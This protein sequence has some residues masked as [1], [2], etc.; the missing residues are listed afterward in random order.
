MTNALWVD[1]NVVHIINNNLPFLNV[2]TTATNAG[3]TTTVYIKPS[4]QRFCLNS[5]S[6]CPQCYRNSI[7]NAYIRRALTHCSSWNNTH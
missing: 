3:F 2:L 4:N 6:E 1:E 5:K 7:I